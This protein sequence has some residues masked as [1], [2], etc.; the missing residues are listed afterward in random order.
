MIAKLGSYDIHY[1]RTMSCVDDKQSLEDYEEQ[2][3][4]S[5][6]ASTNSESSL[7]VE[8]KEILDQIKILKKE[9]KV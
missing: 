6:N 9:I 1:I 7:S 8:E 2:Q 5:F 3:G 4:S